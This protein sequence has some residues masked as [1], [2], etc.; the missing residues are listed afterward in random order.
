MLIGI[1]FDN[2]IACYDEGFLS[3]ARE[4]EL[5]PANFRGG[6]KAVRDAVRKGAGGDIAWQ[7]LQA[8]LY[9]RDI[10]QA[11]LADGVTMLLERARLRNIPVAV[12]SHK[13]QFS[14]FDAATDLRLAA[15]AWME[16][17]GLF[18]P[19]GMGV[20]PENVF[21]EATRHDK[22]RR[23]A[24]LGCTHFIDDLDEV[25]HESEFPDGVR[26]YLYAAGYDEIPSG[27][28]R[29]FRTH[30]QIADHLLGVDPR[31]AAMALLGGSVRA[32]A[33][34]ARSGNNRLYRVT[35]AGGTVA[36]K[37]Y[38]RPDDDTRDRLR[39]EYGALSFLQSQSEGAVPAPIAMQRDIHAALYQ[40]IDGTVISSPNAADIDAALMFLA[41]LHGYRNATGAAALPLASEACLSTAEI[42]RQLDARAVRLTESASNKPALEQFLEQWRGARERFAAKRPDDELPRSR[43]TLSPSDFGFH[44]ALRTADGRIVF[45]DFEYFGWDDPAKLTAD[46]LL[47]PAMTLDRA[48]R[49]RFAGGMLS[50]HAD[51]SDFHARLMRHLPLYALRWC[52]ILLNE[53][54]PERWARRVVVGEGDAVAARSRQLEKAETMLHRVETVSEDLP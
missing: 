3:V 22:L 25:F 24:S 50:V 13:T 11:R 5:V 8:R 45:V 42:V 34:L 36:L 19:A 10:G 1:D 7:M 12:I 31:Q 47:H 15:K 51:D 39:T 38:P 17:N 44:N 21:F 28:F 48:C 29:A 14:P 16:T 6:K 40:W 49:R 20:R 46:F 53:F 4:M 32:I 41:R 18:D 37:S 23:I 54:L 27:R 35:G 9:G 43:Q 30:R 26:S 2:T 33:P 52:L